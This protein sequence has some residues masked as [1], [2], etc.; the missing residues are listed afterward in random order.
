MTLGKLVT[1]DQ[2]LRALVQLVVLARIDLAN[3]VQ[4]YGRF[5]SGAKE[6]RAKVR[7]TEQALITANMKF[8]GGEPR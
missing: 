7:R 2:E 3:Y 1:S 6:R 4:V 8:F 5:D